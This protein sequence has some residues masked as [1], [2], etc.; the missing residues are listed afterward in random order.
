M[1]LNFLVYKMKV[2]FKKLQV[3]VDLYSANSISKCVKV[4][5]ICES[6]KAYYLF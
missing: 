3:N 4:Y 2:V 1:A 6:I 5:E